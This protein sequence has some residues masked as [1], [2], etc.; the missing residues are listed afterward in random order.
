MLLDELNHRVKN[1]LAVVQAVALQ[2]LRHSGTPAEVQSALMARLTALARSHDL[3]R[4]GEWEGA[5]LPEIVGQSLAPYAAAV[6]EGRVVMTGPPVR[7]PSSAVLTANLAFHELATNAAK[8]G[9]L[10]VPEGRVEV[11]WAIDGRQGEA[12]AVEIVWRECGGPPVRPPERRGFGSRLIESGLAREFGA[13]VQL[14]FAPEGVECHI[15][16][17]LVTKLAEP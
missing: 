10:S 8:H 11:G 2:T 15:R 4:Q 14:D 17:P 5:S 16:L 1:T 13:E 3:L 6:G 9:S 12:S 7:L